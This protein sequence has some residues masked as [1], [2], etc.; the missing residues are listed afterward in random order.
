MDNEIDI[1]SA[2]SDY[3][4][5][6]QGLS[7]TFDD[8]FADIESHPRVNI[9][10]L[11]VNYAPLFELDFQVLAGL[12][13]FIFSEHVPFDLND[14]KQAIE[15]FLKPKELPETILSSFAEEIESDDD[16][17][18]EEALAFLSI[19]INI[20]LALLANIKAISIN[21]NS[22]C[23]LIA[24]ARNNN[25][26]DALLE[27]IAIDQVCLNTPTVQKAIVIARVVDDNQFFDK[28]SRAIKGSRPR[29]QNVEYDA[30]R[31]L[32]VLID[33]WKNNKPLTNDEIC[34]IFIDELKIYPNTGKD[35]YA[36]LTKF[37]Q[38]F[39]KK[40]KRT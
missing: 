15:Y 33:S 10:T 2:L 14:E 13:F 26:S 23:E 29:N 38:N 25:D 27:A 36:G 30:A 1:N 24:R 18:K 12:I 11:N 6:F 3:N 7:S 37:L 40:A 17:G 34:H 4:D 5:L 39:R 16:F 21:G 9:D 19:L 8:L 28:L 20:S 22:I 32:S 31:F 35:D